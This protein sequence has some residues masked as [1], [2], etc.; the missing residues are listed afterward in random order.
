MKNNVAFSNGSL[1][2]GYNISGEKAYEEFYKDEEAIDLDR[3]KAL[4]IITGKEI[5]DKNKVMVLFDR[6]NNAFNSEASKEKII[7]I[8]KEYLLNFGHIE[9]S[10]SLDNKM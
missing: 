4:G 7:S 1:L 2:A 9:T 3:L 6:L 5:P 8:M 10:K